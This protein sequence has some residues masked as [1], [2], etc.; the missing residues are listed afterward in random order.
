MVFLRE[1]ENCGASEERT[2]T[3]SWTG[4]ELC[5]QCLAPVIG[6]VTNSPASE[7]RD[8]LKKLIDYAE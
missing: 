4:L 2:F 7:G 3:D 8:N 6:Y 5:L 1:C